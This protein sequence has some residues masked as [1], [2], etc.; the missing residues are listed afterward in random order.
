MFL[1]IDGTLLDIAPS[2]YAVLVPQGLGATLSTLRNRLGGALALIS[3]RAL[4]SIDS[5]FQPMRLPAAGQHGAEIRSASG[6]VVRVWVSPGS[7]YALRQEV[8]RVVADLPG[9]LIEP[10]SMG[11]AVHYRQVPEVSG[12]LARRLTDVLRRRRGFHMMCG[13]FVFELKPRDANKARAIEVFMLHDPFVGRIP[14]FVGDDRADEDGFAAATR[15]GGHA[16][17]V[18]T[19][20]AGMPGFRLGSAREVR[21]W[22]ERLVNSGPELDPSDLRCKTST[23]S[24][25]ETAPWSL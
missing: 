7:P 19:A 25:S 3:G 22:L 2:P 11:I 12:E 4:S 21:A 5:L 9:I 20:Q 16:V 23:S 13:K 17:R 6:D 18:G 1:D 8:G 24:S 10:K 14:V 15:L